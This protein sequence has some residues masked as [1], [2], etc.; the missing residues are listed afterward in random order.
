MQREPPAGQQRVT[1]ADVDVDIAVSIFAVAVDNVCAG[2]FVAF[3]E[4]VVRSKSS[5]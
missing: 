5:V 1:L 4:W 3:F 2:E